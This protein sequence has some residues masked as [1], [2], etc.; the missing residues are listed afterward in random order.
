[1]PGPSQ[2]Q[3]PEPVVVDKRIFVHA[4][5]YHWHQEGGI[6]AASRAAIEQLHKNTHDFAVATVKEVDAINERVEGVSERINTTAA[7]V[8]Q[9]LDM[10]LTS[11][12]GAQ[13]W[14]EIAQKEIGQTQTNLVEGMGRVTAIEASVQKIEEA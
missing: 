4:P 12:Q 1:M 13:R 8:E 7:A 6:D 5:Q 3:G 2:H 14:H 9:Q 10:P 11:G